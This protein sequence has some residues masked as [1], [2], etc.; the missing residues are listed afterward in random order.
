MSKDQ[1]GTEAGSGIR[2]AEA[3][4]DRLARLVEET[5]KASSAFLKPRASG[6]ATGDLSDSIGEI[7]KT[8]A[9]VGESLL[10]EPQRIA[11]AQSRFIG[12]FANVMGHSLRRLAGQ[13]AAPPVAPDPNDRRFNDPEW[14]ENQFFDLIKQTYLISTRLVEELVEQANDLDPHTRLKA[15]FY[16]R[17]IANALAPSNFLLTNP[18]LLRESLAAK[19]ENL[20]RGMR[21]LAEDLEAGGGGLKIRQSDMAGFKVGENL[22]TTPGKVIFQNDLCQLI[23]YRATTKTV[24]KRPLLIVPP[25]IN[26]FY[27][28]DLNKE[29]SFIRWAVAQGHT[30]FVISWI[31]PDERHG[32]KSL[33]DYMSEGIFESLNV[34]EKITGTS[35]L[36][37]LGYCVGGTLLSIA[38]AYAAA[39][40]DQRIKSATLL[41]TQVDFTHAGELKV[42]I[43]EDQIANLENKMRSRGFLDAGKMAQVFNLLRSNELIWP[44]FI[45]NYVRGKSPAPFD[46]LY[47]N[48]DSTR[49]PAAN[50][51]FYL[52][53]CYLENRLA[54][55]TMEIAGIRINLKDSK[56]PTYNL[57]TRQ[58]HI[59]PP[60]SAFLGASLFGGRAKFVLSGSGHIAGV[61]NPPST[62]KYQY[63]TGPAPKGDGFEKWLE[64]AK[65]HP[66]SWWPH[67][68]TWIESLDGE[69]VKARPIGRGKFKSIEDAPGSYVKVRS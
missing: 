29:K 5:G 57:A 51:A 34:I 23:Q 31:N 17:Q 64:K 9:R 55:G 61:I 3:F 41:A 27:I 25:W 45:N 33:D 52:R 38:L 37:A 30:V 7:V 32:Q 66:G 35:E 40:G 10:A 21:L 15:A 43:D 20:I 19:G 28:L 58:D 50:H 4:L 14:S 69:R 63:W 2:D 67:W 22:A 49:M 12:D 1:S 53:N 56:I 65:E 11:E 68:Q 6:A 24:L 44:F 62:N 42:F 18:E 16:V 26:K 60:R 36:N 13:P 46:L 54:E 47:W 59:A 39:K 8:F 48:S